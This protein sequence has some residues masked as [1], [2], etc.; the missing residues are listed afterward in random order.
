MYMLFLLLLT[1]S[2][3]VVLASCMFFCFSSITKQ[4]KWSAE[5]IEKESKKYNEKL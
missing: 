5:I 3:I 4:D 1:V 2:S